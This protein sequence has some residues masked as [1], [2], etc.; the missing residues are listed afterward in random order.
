MDYHDELILT[1]KSSPILSMVYE[2][3]THRAT[4][5]WLT[6]FQFSNGKVASKVDDE[7]M[8]AGRATSTSWTGWAKSAA[9]TRTSQGSIVVFPNSNLPIFCLFSV[10]FNFRIQC[11][12]R[13]PRFFTST[14]SINRHF[15]TPQPHVCMWLLAEVSLFT[16]LCCRHLLYHSCEV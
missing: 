13:A 15:G 5:I 14:C 12:S 10:A 7:S 6:V 8:D 11:V 3:S 1:F 2:M 9:P 4:D 16:A